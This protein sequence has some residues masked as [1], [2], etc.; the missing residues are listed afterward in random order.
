MQT[1]DVL[2]IGAGQAGLALGYHL[3]Q[4]SLRFLLTEQNVRV[5]DSWRKRY[6]SLIL[7]TP[8][9]YS[10]LPG[11]PVPGDPDGYPTKDEIADYLE[12]YAYHFALPIRTGT[13]IQRLERVPD[14]FHA[15]TDMGESIHCRAVV[16]ANGAF[17]TPAIPPTARNLAPDVQQFSSASYKHPGQIPAGQ[18]LVVGDGATG[19]QI[20]LE[21]IATHQVVLATGRPRRVFPAHILG[22]SIFWWLQTLGIMNASRETA[23]GRYLMKSDSFPG[24][25]LEFR[26]LRRQG[27]VT[28]GRVVRADGRRVTFEGRDS[29]T[30]DAVI[31]A[32][33]YHENTDWVTIPEAKDEAGNFIH[34]RGVTP[35][36]GLYL[37]GRSWQWTRGSALLAGVGADAECLVSHI[38]ARFE[39]IKTPG[40]QSMAVEHI[41]EVT[42]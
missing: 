35:V 25:N 20:A 8:H 32:T 36:P 4:T 33:G 18:V 38:M 16:L 5:G 26:Q 14:G 34:Q 3:K 23:I 2:I 42:R 24:K 9:A 1:L 30:V 22:R 21:L 17:Q 29:T 15:I 37:I 39:Q 31:W 40:K 7:F 19:R 10:A 13:G 6:D 12:A 28:V 27:V 11:L 41:H